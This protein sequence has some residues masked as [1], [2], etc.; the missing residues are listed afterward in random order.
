MAY[1]IVHTG[2]KAPF[3]GVQTGFWSPAYH[4]GSA[5]TTTGVPLMPPSIEPPTKIA[6]FFSPPADLSTVST[7]DIVGGKTE[8]IT[9][10]LVG[11]FIRRKIR[12]DIGTEGM[13]WKH[14]EAAFPTRR[15]K[16]AGA[17]NFI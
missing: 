8:T 2:A 11:K 12:G 13:V 10:L 14:S 9:L 15:I 17:S 5:R 7:P 1:R 3:L 4:A 16:I 6:A